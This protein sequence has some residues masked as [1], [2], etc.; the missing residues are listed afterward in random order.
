ME[1]INIISIEFLGFVLVTLAVYYLISL[2]LPRAVQNA[3]LLA[4]SY[5]FYYTWSDFFVYIL[6][7][8]TAVNFGLGLWLHS[9]PKHKKAILWF[10]ILVNTTALAWYLVGGPYIQTL[11]LPVQ[12]LFELFPWIVLP[13]GMS[14]Y[15]LNSI[16]YLVD[17]SLRIAKPTNNILDFALYLAYFPKLISGPLERARKFLPMLAEARVVD[18]GQIAQ[19]LTLI[20]V[21]LLRAAILGGIF[22]LYQPGM[23]LEHPAS[24]DSLSLL[25]AMVTFMFYIYNQFAGYTDIVRGV[26]GLFGI[27]L[28][29]N[30]MHPFFSKDFSDF[31]QRWHIS[32]SQWLR[33]YIYMPISRAF[34]RRNPSR[35]NI[36]N[37]IIPPLVTMLVSGFWHGAVP[38]LLVW[39]LLM[40]LFIVIE[41][42]RALSRPAVPQQTIPLWRKITGPA[43]LLVLMLIATAPFNLELKDTLAYYRQLLLGWDTPSINFLPGLVIPISLLL[44]WFQ[45]RSGDETTF[46]NWPAW[47]QVI[48]IV[49]IT[50][51]T[52]VIQQLQS[53]PAVFVY[54]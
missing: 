30:F 49:S 53:A 38:N 52:I 43:S 13:V 41:N 1:Q 10:G 9:N 44:D 32:L 25:W 54:P 46:R 23:P 3:W 40:G 18:N 27:P 39:G 20:L 51:G 6:A 2:F 19:S 7:A 17:I 26:S 15:I 28:T 14:Y 21:G 22:S 48:L 29:R 50:M 36:P 37:L 35:T 5:Y 11:N 33:D 47:I 8:M 31:W 42:I 16:S 12:T 45:S 24:S 4:A 34:L